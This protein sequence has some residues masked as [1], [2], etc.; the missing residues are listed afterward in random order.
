MIISD[1]GGADKLVGGFGDD[2]V[3][4]STFGVFSADTE[5]DGNMYYIDSERGNDR[6]T[7]NI[8]VDGDIAV[9]CE[10]VIAG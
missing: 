3:V 7:I 2:Q 4:H 5:S 1:R 9:H 8:S 10:T 6:A